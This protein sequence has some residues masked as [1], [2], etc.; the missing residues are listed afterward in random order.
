MKFLLYL[1]AFYFLYRFIFSGLFKV[2]VYNFNQHNHYKQQPEGQEEGKITIDPKV[3]PKSKDTDKK[4]GE[5]VDFEE[6]K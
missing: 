2:R 1:F 5:Y 4:L 3:K 6:V